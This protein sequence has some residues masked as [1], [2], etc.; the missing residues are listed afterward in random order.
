MPGKIKITATDRQSYQLYFQT[1]GG[2]RIL[3]GVPRTDKGQVIEDAAAIRRGVEE[4]SRYAVVRDARGRFSFHFIG[5]CG[6]CLA[7]SQSYSTP[8]G[9]GR[10]IAALK[11]QAP[12]AGLDDLT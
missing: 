12:Q 4:D 3:A 2:E 1:L 10:A 5:E 11:A 8:E 7:V 6:E 9:L